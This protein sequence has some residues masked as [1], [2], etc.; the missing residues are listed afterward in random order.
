MDQQ[1]VSRPLSNIFLFFLLFFH[2]SAG[3]AGM[4]SARGSPQPPPG[5]APVSAG[6]SLVPAPALSPSEIRECRVGPRE[7][8]SQLL[9]PG[10]AERMGNPR[11]G[12][13]ARRAPS[14]W[15]SREHLPGMLHFRWPRR[16]EEWDPLLLQV[17]HQPPPSRGPNPPLQKPQGA[18][19]GASRSPK[20]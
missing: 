19:A 10:R 1:L 6:N 11:G 16:Q 14:G 7:P 2:V 4:L 20:L 3:D 8:G 15:G 9:G 18:L 13:P 5:A 12:V 17:D